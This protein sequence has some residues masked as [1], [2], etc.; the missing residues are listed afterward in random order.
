VNR[1]EIDELEVICWKEKCWWDHRRPSM[2][3]EAIEHQIDR[4]TKFY[5][6]GNL[7]STHTTV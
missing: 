3:E 5:I 4:I 7:S 1:E 2:N 6:D